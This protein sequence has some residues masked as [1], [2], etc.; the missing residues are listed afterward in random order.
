MAGNLTERDLCPQ[1]TEVEAFSVFVRLMEE[2][3]PRPSSS[4]TTS[5]PSTHSHRRYALR[6]LF[7][8]QMT[9]LH[10]LLHQH[11][12]LVRLHLPNLYAHFQTHGITATM[13]ASQWFL[14]LFTYNFP[15]PL[16]FRIFDIIF[17]EGASETM[18]RF[19]LAILKRNEPSLLRE[20]EFEGVLDFLK[21]GK[22]YKVYEE[23]P[24]WVLKD[25]ASVQE[26]VSERGLNEI[27][28]KYAVV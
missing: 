22:L 13:Y 26:L 10:L 8:T 25:A 20:D 21:G 14:T 18:L 28:E 17:A 2:N 9:G 11:T 24:E 1:M 27:A 19:S 4:A 3:P 5:T 15:L 7:T 6:T 12:E 16:V 23:D